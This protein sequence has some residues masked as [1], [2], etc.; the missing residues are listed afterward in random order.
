MNIPNALTVI[1]FF[2]IP[3]FVYLYFLPVKNN[4]IYAIAVFVVAGIT[5]VI[6]G[7]IA[8]KYN[9]V[10]KFGMLLDP[11]ADK[12][13]ILT[14]LFCFY[15]KGVIPLIVILII[16]LKEIFMIFGAAI[17]YKKNRTTIQS[18]SFGKIATAMFY[19]G[20]ILIAFKLF[21]GYYILILAV[22][23]AIIAFVTYA[24]RFK[25]LYKE[26]LLKDS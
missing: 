26:K 1:R 4:I 23:F 21:I 24:Y 18:N 16:L 9:V 5:D 6:D 3:L 7:Y 13:M 22:I 11:L 25:H 19:I 2:L 20:V 12:L 17:L 10:T 15:I 8:R 14:V